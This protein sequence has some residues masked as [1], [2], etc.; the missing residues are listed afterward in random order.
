VVVG[1]TLNIGCLGTC[2]F[3]QGNQMVLLDATGALSGTFSSVTYTGLPPGSFSVSYDNA[4]GRVILTATAPV[5][6]RR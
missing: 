5:N 1:G 3:V 6:L 2:S 4:G